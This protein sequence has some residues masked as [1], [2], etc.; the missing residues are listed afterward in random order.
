[1][2]VC[3]MRSCLSGIACACVNF[4]GDL[5]PLRECEPDLD[6]DLLP[7][8]D[9]DVTRCALDA[10]DV[11]PT[12]GGRRFMSHDLRDKDECLLSRM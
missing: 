8:C 2:C 11:T 9:D 5:L 3:M 1:M 4:V 6:G 12:T 10:S 7:L